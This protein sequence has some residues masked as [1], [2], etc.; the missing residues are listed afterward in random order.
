MALGTVFLSTLLLSFGLSLVIAGLFG[1]Y[2]GQ[3]RSRSIGFVLI[4]VAVLMIGLFVALTWPIV[5]GVEP[6]F[7]GRI[8]LQSI[9]A[10]LGATAG[11]LVA[12]LA[13]VVAVMR[14]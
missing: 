9:V 6:V 2:F 11:S 14:S 1:A 12:V 5:P 8:V 7:Q 3:G 10:V 13:F 4:L